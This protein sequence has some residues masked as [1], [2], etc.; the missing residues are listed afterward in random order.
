[1]ENRNSVKQEECRKT[2]KMRNARMMMMSSKI[3]VNEGVRKQE[4]CEIGE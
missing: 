1:V 2:G 3:E 4:Q